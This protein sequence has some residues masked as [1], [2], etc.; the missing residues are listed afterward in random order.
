MHDSLLFEKTYQTVRELCENNAIKK[1]NEIKMAVSLDSHV[2]GPHILSHFIERDNALFGGWTTVVVEKRD[3]EKLTAV[4]QS[5][6]G[7]KE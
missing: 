3:I 5:I 2:N 6:D 7:E 1:V 4:V